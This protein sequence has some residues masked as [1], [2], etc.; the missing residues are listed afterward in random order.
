MNRL[1]RSD[2]GVEREG[3]FVKCHVLYVMEEKD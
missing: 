2:E 3:I 1:K